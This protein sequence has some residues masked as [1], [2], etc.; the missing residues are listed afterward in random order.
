MSDSITQSSTPQASGGVKDEAQSAA[1][2]VAGTAQEG[3]RNV[4]HEARSQAR[5]LWGQS[6]DEMVQQAGQQ[7]ARLAGGLRDLGSQLQSM[8][9]GSQQSGTARTPSP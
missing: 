9:E 4:A 5:Q 7:Q 2:D 1:K 3:A 8:A 6:R